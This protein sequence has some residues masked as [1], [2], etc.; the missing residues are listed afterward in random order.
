MGSLT[1]RPGNSLTI[2]RMA[3]SIGSI[4]F[5]S[6]M[7]AIQATGLLTLAPVGMISPTEHASLRWTTLLRQKSIRA[8][9]SRCD[10]FITVMEAAE[11]RDLDDPSDAGDL[12]SMR[13]LLVQPQMGPRRVVVSE[14]G[15][16]GPLEM[17][18]IQDHE[19][20]QAVSSD[21]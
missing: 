15:S 6:S 19:V 11:L 2:P 13:T 4:H 17:S 14:I 12:P 20:V 9:S 18:R 8:K 1:L 5:V 16:Q 21:R 7:N 10:A 3:L